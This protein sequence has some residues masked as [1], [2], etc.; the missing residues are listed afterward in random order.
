MSSFWGISWI[1]PHF[2][3]DFLNWPPPNNPYWKIVPWGSID[4]DMVATYKYESTLKN[5]CKYKT[6]YMG[7]NFLSSNVFGNFEIKNGF[8]IRRKPLANSRPYFLLLLLL[9]LLLT[10]RLIFSSF[11][12]C[13]TWCDYSQMSH[14]PQTCPNLI[15]CPVLTCPNLLKLS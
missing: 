15:F 12:S 5:F 11:S 7:N 3:R 10:N 9:L 8:L 14:M 4:T 1:N 6:S 2:L 13:I